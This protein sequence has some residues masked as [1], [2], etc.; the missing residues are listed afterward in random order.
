MLN[1][2]LTLGE[3]YMDG[4][5]VLTKGDLYDLLELGARNLAELEGQPWAKALGQGAHRV[6]RPAPAQ[7]PAARQAQCRQPLR[8]RPAALR[9]LPRSRPPIFLRLFR[10]SRPIARRCANR[11]E[12][13]YRR[14]SCCRRTAQGARHRLRV[15]AVSG[16]ISRSVAARASP[17]LRLSE[18]QFAVATA[19]APRRRARRPG[20]IPAAGLSRRRRDRSTASS[21]SACSSTSASAITTSSSPRCATCSRTTG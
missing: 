7:Q 14:R 5:L 19:R 2:A 9:S 3:L 8:P 13:A 1:P 6:S 18:E 10:I 16:S 17:G 15:G 20:R 4:R 11:Q 12:A 21:R